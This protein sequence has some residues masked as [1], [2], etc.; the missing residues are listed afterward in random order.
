MQ[1]PDSLEES[2]KIDGA[3]DF[4]ILF[5]II[6][7]LSKAVIAVMIL[8]YGVEHWNA[9]FN[10]MIFIRRRDLYPLQTILRE[11][12]VASSTESMTTGVGS[13]DQEALSE[14]IKYATI[15]VATFPILTVYP[16][17][18]KYF[19]KGVMLGGIKG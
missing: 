1:I 11:I 17:L 19:V 9:W 5:R 15:I 10:A 8:F 18:Q 12:L 7:P 4:I 13:I 14:T 6:M 3:N 2:A 16:F